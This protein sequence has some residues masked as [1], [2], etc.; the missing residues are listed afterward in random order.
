M[1]EKNIFGTH[2]LMTLT[3][4]AA[5]KLTD[6]NT[7]CAFT[8]FLIDEYGLEKV[9]QVVHKFESQGFTASFCLKESH[10]CIHTWPEL[11]SLTLDVYLCNYSQDN[12]DKVQE[13]SASYIRYFSASIVKRNT[14]ER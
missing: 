9:G 10:I 14:I 11:K 7:F 3:T 6:E 8:D 1:E 4:S 12:T 5:D 13:I 2:S